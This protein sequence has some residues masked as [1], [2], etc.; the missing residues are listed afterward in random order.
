M[1]KETREQ[2]EREINKMQSMSKILLMSHMISSLNSILTKNSTITYT[3]VVNDNVVHCSQAV[4]PKGNKRAA[5]RTA[6]RC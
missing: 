5:G 4:C 1:L 6:R 3:V 2:H